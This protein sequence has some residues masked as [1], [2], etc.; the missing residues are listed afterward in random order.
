VK[1]RAVFLADL[2]TTH[3]KDGEV[4]RGCE[5]A[6][7]AAVALTTAGYATSAERLHEFCALVDPWHDR[8][9]VKDLDERL[10]RI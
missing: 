9:S 4:D 3:V 6:A 7:E 5:L 2:A 1:Q 8:A 10:T